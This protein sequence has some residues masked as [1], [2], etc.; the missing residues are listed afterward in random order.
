VRW[1]IPA[2]EGALRRKLIK[3]LTLVVFRARP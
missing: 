3:V 2:R 1:Y